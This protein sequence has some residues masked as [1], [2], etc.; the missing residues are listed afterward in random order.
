VANH[1]GVTAAGL[2]STAEDSHHV[3]SKVNGVMSSLQAQVAGAGNGWCQVEANRYLTQVA[4]VLQSVD[5]ETHLFDYYS[6]V[7]GQAADAFEQP[8]HRVGRTTAVDRAVRSV[9]ARWS[10]ERG[11]LR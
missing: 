6:K 7:L 11:N 4:W 3:S 5:A 2:R 8:G 1:F 10:G 9:C